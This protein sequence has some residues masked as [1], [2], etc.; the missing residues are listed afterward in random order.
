MFHREDA[1][2]GKDGRRQEPVDIVLDSPVS[3]AQMLGE[4]PG[5]LAIPGKEIAGQMEQILVAGV[6]RYFDSHG[7]EL[8]QY[9]ADCGTPLRQPHRAIR[10]Q[11]H[12]ALEF[13]P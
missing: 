4:Q 13:H 10:R 7:C 9:G 8:E 2:L 11:P 5:L 1:R 6:Q 3:G 12:R